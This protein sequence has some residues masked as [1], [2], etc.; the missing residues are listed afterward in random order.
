VSD[1]DG[2]DVEIVKHDLAKDRPSRELLERL[3]DAKNRTSSSV[4]SCS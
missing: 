1:L 4:R 3:I 2:R